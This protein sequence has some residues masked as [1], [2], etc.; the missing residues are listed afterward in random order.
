MNGVS[1]IHTVIITP[2]DNVKNNVTERRP[3]IKVMSINVMGLNLP[4][5]RKG[6]SN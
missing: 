2:E 5:Q 1:I 4:I 6:L 3:N